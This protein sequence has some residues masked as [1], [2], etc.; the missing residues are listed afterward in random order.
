MIVDLIDV[1]DILASLTIRSALEYSGIRVN[2]YPIATSSQLI[3]ALNGGAGENGYILLNCHG[4]EGG[5]H[6]PELGAEVAKQQPFN[7]A[8][9]AS[10]FRS[11]LQLPPCTVVNTGCV[12][13]TPDYAGAF[14]EG[15]C[16]SYIGAT[17]YPDGNA[18]LMYTIHLFYW[19]QR[20]QY[21]LEHA[22]QTAA[23]IDEDTGMYTLYP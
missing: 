1:D 12:L 11:F 22:H 4:V 6:L 14:L 17:D 13:G 19:L 7:K 16:T 3:D 18:A 2:F 15:G 5:L 20:H 21:S 23:S 9:S 10:D 8:V